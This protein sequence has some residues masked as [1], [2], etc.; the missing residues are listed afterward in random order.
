MTLPDRSQVVIIGGGVVGCSIA[1]HLAQRGVTDVVLVERK[2][3]TNG[4][5]WH[6][7]GLVGQLRSSSNLTQLMRQSVQTYRGPRAAHRIPDRLARCGQPAPGL[8]RGSL[9]GAQ[10]DRDH[11]PQL[12]LRRRAGLGDPGRRAVPAARPDRCP[13]SDLGALRRVRR[14][15]PADPVLRERRPGGRRTDRAELP[16]HRGGAG[17]PPGHRR[18]HRTGPDRVRHRGQR[19]GHVGRRD[20][21]AGRCQRRRECGRAPVRRHRAERR[22]PARP[23]DAARPGRADLSQAGERRAR[24]RRLGGRHAC[25]LATH[26]P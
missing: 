14:P 9:G 20:R 10:T 22:H 1:Y 4:S 18:G 21:R 2:S 3:L 6:A 12:R 13:R 5:T 19:H 23:A 24:P 8:Q 25:A 11:R 16:G 17:R 26:P 7:A 15:E